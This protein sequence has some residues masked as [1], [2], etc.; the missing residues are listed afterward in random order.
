MLTANY[1][2]C[3]HGLHTFIVPIRDPVNLKTYPGITIGDM[4]EKIGLNGLDNGFIVFDRYRV[5]R[6]ALLDKNGGINEDGK[7]VSPFKDAK[8]KM[9]AS[10][11]NLSF[12]RMGIMNMTNQNLQLAVTIAIR[13]SAVRKQFGAKE[14]HG[15]LAVLEYQTQQCRLFPF[16]AAAGLASRSSFPQQHFNN[17]LQSSNHKVPATNPMLDFQTQ[18]ILN[19]FRSAQQQHQSLIKVKFYQCRLRYSHIAR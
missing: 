4:G 10:L 5:S 13:Y 11:A 18:T 8:K 12:G 16:L 1:F 17:G 9:G 19:M 2:Y 15:E 3:R 14:A 6:D 7:Y